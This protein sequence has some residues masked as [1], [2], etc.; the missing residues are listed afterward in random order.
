M[1]GANASSGSPLSLEARITLNGTEVPGS[2]ISTI[3]NANAVRQ[4]INGSI[5]VACSS[6]NTVV[7][8]ITSN[9]TSG[10]IV[11]GG[12]TTYATTKISATMTI[13]RIS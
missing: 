11:P 13:T 10:Q 7:L 5:L 2:Q 1:L 8:Q 6:G 3:L 4:P 12:A 9:K